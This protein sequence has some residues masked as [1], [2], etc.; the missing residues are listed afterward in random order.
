MVHPMP[1][2]AAR[3]LEFLN[4]PHAENFAQDLVPLLSDFSHSV[5]KGKLPVRKERGLSSRSICRSCERSR[6][7]GSHQTVGKTSSVG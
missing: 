3:L 2:E 6:F 7:S 5:D 4:Q 1:P